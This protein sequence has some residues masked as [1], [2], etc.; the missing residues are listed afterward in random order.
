MGL[1]HGA[2]TRRCSVDSAAWHDARAAGAASA[3]QGWLGQ[4]GAA[5]AARREDGRGSM[6]Q[7]G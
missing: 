1:W 3:V 5:G 6:E 7:Q 2:S 4:R